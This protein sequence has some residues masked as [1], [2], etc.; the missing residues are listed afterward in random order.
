MLITSRFQFH[1]GY[2]LPD[3]ERGHAICDTT[4]SLLFFRF[5]FQTEFCFYFGCHIGNIVALI[6]DQFLREG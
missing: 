2:P 6:E 3:K 4:P 5:L 1:D